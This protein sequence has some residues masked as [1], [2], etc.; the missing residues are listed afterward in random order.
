MV[1]CDHQDH[2]QPSGKVTG[3]LL[4]ALGVIVVFMVV[5][6]V[7]GILSGSLALLAD[8]THMLTDA[9][10]LALA[11]SAQFFSARPADNKLHFGYRRAQV[12]AAFVNGVLLAV[13]LVWIVFEAVRRFMEPVEV[14]AQLMLWVAVAGFIA[15]AIAFFILHR[16]DEQN[17]NMR[18]AMLHVVS[19]LLGS[20]AAIIA[21]LVIA[22]TGWLAIDPILSIGVAF[23]IGVSALRLVRETGFI[24]LEGA[25][26]GIDVAELESELVKAVQQIKGVHNVQISQITPE[27]PRLTLHACVGDARD[28]AGALATAKA[29]LEDRYNIRHST[30]QIEIGEECPDAPGSHKDPVRH[31]EVHEN[32]APVS[33]PLKA[34]GGSAAYATE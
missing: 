2:H 10:A 4:M 19:D 14:N 13:L 1:N 26:P 17:L 34:Q 20:A 5:E 25:P 30:I 23:L 18:G 28:A 29:F 27:Q 9:L 32:K 7:G 3:R 24:L 8:A 33:K 6:V 12:L 11:V 15:N 22:S 31:F 16:R 21:A